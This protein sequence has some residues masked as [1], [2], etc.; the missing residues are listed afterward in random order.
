ME[1]A[2][3][4]GLIGLGY[5]VSRLAG[6]KTSEGFKSR[7]QDGFGMTFKPKSST[8]A[9][10]SPPKSALAYTPQGA[11]AVGNGS[12]LDMFYATPNGRTYPSEPSPGPYGMPVGYGTQNPPLSPPN[13]RLPGPKPITVE[14]FT[15]QVRQNPAGIEAN[16]EY[17]SDDVKSA[18]SG[19]MVP[20]SEFKHNNMVPFFGG[21]VKQNMRANAN[22]SVLE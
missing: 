2:A 10:T 11:S 15:P 4:A 16:P 14:D 8:V 3:L 19:Q 6:K 20:P 17:L 9:L 7:G 18:L 13:G 1:A 22:N 5:A 21:R 12:D